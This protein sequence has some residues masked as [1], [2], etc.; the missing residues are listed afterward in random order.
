MC[1]LKRLFC[2]IYRFP[3]YICDTASQPNLM[4]LQRQQVPLSQELEPVEYL[5]VKSGF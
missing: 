1:S 4:T 2:G 5:S 3:I